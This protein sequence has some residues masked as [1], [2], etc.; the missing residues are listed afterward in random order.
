M[1]TI[2]WAKIALYLSSADPLANEYRE[3]LE[4]AGLNFDVLESL[5]EAGL[6]QFDCLLMAGYGELS[7]M[8]AQTVAKWVTLGGKLVVSGSTF[9]LSALLGLKAKATHLSQGQIE[10][11]KDC[12]L[13]PSKAEPIVF[14]GARVHEAADATVVA[15]AQGGAALTKYLLGRGAAWYVAAHLGQTAH[16]MQLGRS[17]ETDGIGPADGSVTLDDGILR[18]EDGIALDWNLHRRSIEPNTPAIFPQPHADCLREMWLRCVLDALQTTRKAFSM[19]WHWPD[20]A[21]TIGMVTFEAELEA[22]ESIR[23]LSRMVGS[24]GVSAAWLSPSPGYGGDLYRYLKA[25]DHEAGILF[26]AHEFGEWDS[27]KLKVQHLAI[28][29]ASSS[30]L[31]AAARPKDGGWYRHTKFFEMVDQLGIRLLVS[32][33]GRQPGSQGFPF[34]SCIMRRPL[35]PCGTPYHCYDLPYQMYLPGFPDAAAEHVIDAVAHRH[36]C[37]HIAADGSLA[38]DIHFSASLRRL[39]AFAKQHHMRFYVPTELTHYEEARRK[40]RTAV[41][42]DGTGVEFMFTSQT[43]LNGLTLLIGGIEEPEAILGGAMLNPEHCHRYGVAMWGLKFN[44]EAKLPSSVKLRQV[45][46]AA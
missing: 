18:A 1:S 38:E 44:L 14:F 9:G 42:T 41:R 23:T 46:L 2:A 17:V 10:C 6:R 45:Q 4:H 34:G 22:S 19:L 7:A 24:L 15:T 26:Q 21:S 25:I 33:G 16:Q 20:N 8:E 32:R 3:T 39:L 30:P 12:T 28:T 31:A 36:G 11:V 43:D 27:E 35:R 5:D 37:F 40:L 29:R 13:W